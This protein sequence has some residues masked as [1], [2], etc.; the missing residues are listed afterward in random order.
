MKIINRRYRIV[1]V[2]DSDST[3]ELYHAV[4]L[5]TRNRDVRLKLF[6]KEYSKSDRVR[7]YIDDFLMWTTVNHPNICESYAFEC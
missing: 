7:K 2:I 3:G 1:D 6:T 5:M 4:D